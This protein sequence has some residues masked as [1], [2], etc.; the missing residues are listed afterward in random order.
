MHKRKRTARRA[1][2]V[3]GA[4]LLV[5]VAASSAS[6][7]LGTQKSLSLTVGP[8][9]VPQVPLE[10]CLD[11]DCLSTPPVNDVTLHTKVSGGATGLVLLTPSVCPSGVGVAASLTAVLGTEVTVEATV[12]GTGP[13]GPVEAGIGPE[14]VTLQPGRTVTVSACVS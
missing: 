6:A 5:G 7:V 14:S 4:V 10:V 2:A 11:D 12:R 1:A 8:A 3:A 13:G 9:S